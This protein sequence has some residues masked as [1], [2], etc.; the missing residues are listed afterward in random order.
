MRILILLM[1]VIGCEKEEAADAVESGRSQDAPQKVI[2]VTDEIEEVE[3]EFVSDYL[4]STDYDTGC[5]DGIRLDIEVEQHNDM[6]LVNIFEHGLSD[7]SDS[8]AYSQE[9]YTYQQYHDEYQIIHIDGLTYEIE[10]IE[11]TGRLLD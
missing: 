8:H 3:E 4:E 1:L 2:S 11:V 9:I 5:I 10:G 7:C 6:V